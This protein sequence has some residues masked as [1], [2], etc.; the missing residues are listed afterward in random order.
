[1]SEHDD[2]EFEDA[3][4]AA[5]IVAT[6]VEE[7]GG[8]GHDDCCAEIDEDD[9]AMLSPPQHSF[10][11]SNDNQPLMDIESP[12]MMTE[13]AGTTPA[14]TKLKQTRKEFQVYSPSDQLISPCTRKL[15]K[16]RLGG[17]SFSHPQHIL[18]A[19]QHEGV[20]LAVKSSSTSSANT[21]VSD[22]NCSISA[23]VPLAEPFLDYEKGLLVELLTA[24]S[25]E[26]VE[27]QQADAGPSSQ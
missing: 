10:N 27:Y 7:S 16:C 23:S 9:Q 25:S 6:A 18:R 2:I 21:A 3:E 20:Q 22:S 4:A 8:R 13:H 12:A 19:R 17:V 24:K 5:T 14:I 1:M 15:E 26:H 11:S